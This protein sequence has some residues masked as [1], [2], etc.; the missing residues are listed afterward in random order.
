M[1]QYFIKREK[2][3]GTEYHLIYIRWF[4][5]FETFFERWNTNETATARLHELQ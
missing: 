2:V 5:L 1:K 3:C 4:N